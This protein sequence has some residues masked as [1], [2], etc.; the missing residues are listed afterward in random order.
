[1]SEPN[2]DRSSQISKLLL[3]WYDHNA[4][5]LPW[6][7]TPAECA[8]GRL[9]DPYHVWLSEIMLQQTTVIT[10]G[11][12]FKNFLSRW[13]TVNALSAAKDADVMAE[14]AGLG[15]Y[16][17]A[18]N[19]LRCARIITHQENGIFPCTEL[20][21][22]KLPGI[23]PY[24]AA[25][26]AA[27][28]YDIPATVLDGNIERV[29]A[30]V[31]AMT[32]FLPEGKPLLRGHAYQATPQKRV[33]DYVQSVMDLGATICTP[34]N[35]KCPI[36]PLRNICIGKAEGIA[37]TLPRKHPKAA[38]PTRRGYVYFAYCQNQ[39]ML[40]ETRPNQGLLGGMLALPSTSGGLAKGTAKNPA[41]FHPF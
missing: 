41:C 13:P 39:T 3:H 7:V 36:C 34:R 37:A 26:I 31:F 11:P 14:W 2:G 29:M 32:A 30:R 35:P 6:R 22:L 12:Y 1:M 21:L 18:R 15:Y 38:K 20:A 19:L 17:R 9:P 27:I 23:G 25:A 10:V 28:A 16:A 5:V 8:A 4:R 24:T 40:L 33:G